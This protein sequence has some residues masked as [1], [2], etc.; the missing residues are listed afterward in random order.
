[1]WARGAGGDGKDETWDDET[2]MFGSCDQS[3]VVSAAFLRPAA[4]GGCG[5][6]VT[7]AHCRPLPL[8]ALLR[9][10]HLRVLGQGTLCRTQASRYSI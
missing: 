6:L 7:G 5:V 8:S 4:E 10:L 2:G 9:P 1:M 3:N